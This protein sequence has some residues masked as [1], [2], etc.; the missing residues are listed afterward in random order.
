MKVLP[1]ILALSLACN[2]QSK[3]QLTIIGAS[4]G[5]ALYDYVGFNATHTNRTA[6]ISYRAS[7]LALLSATTYILGKAYDWKAGAGFL[8]MYWT[9]TD[10]FLYYAWGRM[11]QVWERN[12][13]SGVARNGAT[14][15]YWTPIGLLRG[16]KRN[17]AIAGNTLVVQSLVGLSFGMAIN[18]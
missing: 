3:K 8:V 14:W 10:D 18:F 5:F 4:A 16:M 6:L 11:L 13:F 2:A 1:L 15:A 12:G 7:Q 9:F 17:K